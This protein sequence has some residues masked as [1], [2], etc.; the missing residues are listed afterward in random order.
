MLSPAM[1]RSLPFWIDDRAAPDFD[2]TVTRSESYLSR[3]FDK[4]DVRPLILVMVNVVGKLAKQ[5][6]F[7]PKHSPSFLQERVKGVGEGVLVFLG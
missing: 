2:N 3:S 4:V 7:F 5:N 6:S 1:V